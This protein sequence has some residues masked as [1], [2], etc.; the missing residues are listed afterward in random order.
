MNQLVIIGGGPGNGD[1]ILPAAARAMAAADFV[2]ADQRFI[3]Q[4]PNPNKDV[5]GSILKMPDRVR[6]KLNEGSVAVVVSG[7]PLFYSL[8]K[9]LKAHFPGSRSGSSRGSVL[10]GI[11]R[12]YVRKL[13]KRQCISAPTGGSW[14]LNPF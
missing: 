9:L 10:S 4:I 13:W 5:Y 7:D 2:F 14:I 3:S 8:T 1:Y 12:L 11:L 6:E